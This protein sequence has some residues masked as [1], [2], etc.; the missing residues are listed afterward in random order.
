[1]VTLTMFIITILGIFISTFA[2]VF[3]FF[4]KKEK[5]FRKN[6]HIDDNCIIYTSETARA[7]CKVISMKGDMVEVKD[8]YGKIY[9]KNINDIVSI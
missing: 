6:L 2:V 5:Y 4:N 7:K 8:N 9:T 1:M 3:F